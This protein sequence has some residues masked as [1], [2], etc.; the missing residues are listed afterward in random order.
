MLRLHGGFLGPLLGSLLLLSPRVTVQLRMLLRLGLLF[1]F[2]LLSLRLLFRTVMLEVVRPARW[3][4]AS[5]AMCASGTTGQLQRGLMTV[6]P[7]RKVCCML[8]AA[9]KHTASLSATAP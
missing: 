2:G 3:A 1:P 7:Y 8:H 4:A 9:C 6:C 5:E